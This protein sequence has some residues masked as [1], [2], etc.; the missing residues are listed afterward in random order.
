M[1]AIGHIDPRLGS[2]AAGG[3]SGN[4]PAIGEPPADRP[5]GPAFES[6]LRRAE[7]AVDSVVD[8]FIATALIYPMLEQIGDSPFK[9]SMFDGGFT[10]DSFRSRMNLELADQIA[11]SSSLGVS[12]IVSQRLGQWLGQQTSID[13][14]NGVAKMGIDA[15][16]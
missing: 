5:G 1:D 10:E 4:P 6:A 16:G 14:L 3:V 12:D 8:K 2:A 15:I 13:T 7:K 9:T 11:S